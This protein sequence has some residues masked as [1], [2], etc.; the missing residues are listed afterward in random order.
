MP[1]TRQS[2]FVPSDGARLYYE[3]Y[4][5]SGMGS[6]WFWSPPGSPTAAC[7]MGNSRRS[8]ADTG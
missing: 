5:I 8:H 2:G 6:R 4:E 1:G 3:I 7:G